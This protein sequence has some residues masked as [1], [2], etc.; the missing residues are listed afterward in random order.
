MRGLAVESSEHAVRGRGPAELL[1]GR[2]LDLA[3]RGSE[4]LLERG[5]PFR[6]RTGARIRR[7]GEARAPMFP[8]HVRRDPVD[9][10]LA[11]ALPCASSWRSA[12]GGSLGRAPSAMYSSVTSC[13]SL[14]RA[15]PRAARSQSSC[16][17]PVGRSP[18]A[19]S[20]H[21]GC[22]ASSSATISSANRSRSLIARPNVLSIAPRSRRIWSGSPTSLTRRARSVRTA[23][24]SASTASTARRRFWRSSA[25]RSDAKDSFGACGICRN[26]SSSS[27]LCSV[28]ARSRRSVASSRFTSGLAEHVKSRLERRDLVVGSAER[29]D[30]RRERAP[31]HL[32][33]SA[34][35]STGSS[36]SAAS[37]RPLRGARSAAMAGERSCSIARSSSSRVCM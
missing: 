31:T 4:R 6:A 30:A 35:A 25:R 28:S 36:A 21:R 13:S 8:P 34:T 20:A 9:V 27:S 18:S 29:L 26:R 22:E 14:Y 19:A 11:R 24:I 10:S 15:S 1:V 32:A 7:V 16:S 23:V 12:P 17:R 3:S 37:S 2:V 5:G 33:R